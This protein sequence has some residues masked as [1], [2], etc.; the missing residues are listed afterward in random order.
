MLKV[1]RK[2]FRNAIKACSILYCFVYIVLKGTVAAPKRLEEVDFNFWRMKFT[3]LGDEVNNIEGVLLVTH[4][5][6]IE[7]VCLVYNPRKLVSGNIRIWNEY[8]YFFNVGR[9]KHGNSVISSE[10]RVDIV[11]ETLKINLLESAVYAEILI[12]KSFF[13]NKFNCNA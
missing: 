2:K 3:V 8:L 12:S 9:S 7:H 4:P 13:K 1:V 5:N 10:F 11:R 6:S